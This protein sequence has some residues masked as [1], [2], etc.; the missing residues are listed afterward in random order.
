MTPEAKAA[1]EKVFVEL[2]GDGD[3][4]TRPSIIAA[5]AS[6]IDAHT[7]ELREQVA[8]LVAA[9]N[10]LLVM[11]DCGSEPRKLDEAL[12]WRQNDEQAR[13]DALAAIARA[14]T[15]AAKIEGVGG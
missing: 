4:L 5:F 12:T 11:M 10:G 13:A 1:A 15:D 7:A 8:V 14:A 6:A 2:W 9:C 3:P